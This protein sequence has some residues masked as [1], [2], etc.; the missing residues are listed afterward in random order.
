[1]GELYYNYKLN[2]N[3]VSLVDLITTEFDVFRKNVLY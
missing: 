2:L 1:M 3:V